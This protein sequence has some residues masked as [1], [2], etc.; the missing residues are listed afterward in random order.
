MKIRGKLIDISMAFKRLVISFE[1]TAGKAE[2]IEKYLDRI[3]DISFAKHREKRSLDANACLWKCLSDI[4]RA[5]KTDKWTEYLRALRDYGRYTYILIEHNAVED[6]RRQWR[7]IEVIGEAKY[8]DEE[9]GEIKPMCE[10]L[11][12]YGSS[13]YNSREFSVLLEGVIEDMKDLG[14]DTPL[15]ADVREMIAELE[16]NDRLRKGAI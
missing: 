16:K 13:T 3:L 11:C 2:D 5:N 8:L 4:A 15:R 9:T 7:E 14:L 6:L 12:Y 1:V 10:V